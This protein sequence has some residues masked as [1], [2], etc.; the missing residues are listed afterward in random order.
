MNDKKESGYLLLS[1]A[2]SC[3]LSDGN[4]RAVYLQHYRMVE[5]SVTYFPCYLSMD[6]LSLIPHSFS[7][8]SHMLPKDAISVYKVPKRITSSPKA[9]CLV[10]V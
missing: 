7:L 3:C 2:P 6:L 4:G 5:L 8:T 10:V 1:Q 9:R